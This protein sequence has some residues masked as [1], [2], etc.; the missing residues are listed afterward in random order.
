MQAEDCYFSLRSKAAEFC[1]RAEKAGKRVNSPEL[2]E[3]IPVSYPPHF[4]K[5]QLPALTS[6]LLYV[7]KYK[8]N[9]GNKGFSHVLGYF[10]LVFLNLPAEK[11]F[12]IWNYTK[13]QEEGKRIQGTHIGRQVSDTQVTLYS[14]QSIQQLQITYF[15]PL[16]LTVVPCTC[17][18]IY[19]DSSCSS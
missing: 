13:R 14:L 9:L 12:P 8:I 1:E 7:L 15:V 19:G 11:F 5:W 3:I 16:F 10:Y 2:C 6:H 18:I 17:S 4:R